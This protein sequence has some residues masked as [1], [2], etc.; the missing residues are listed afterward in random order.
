[1][2]NRGRGCCLVAG[3]GFVFLGVIVFQR[4]D[5]LRAAGAVDQHAGEQLGGAVDAG[6]DVAAGIFLSDFLT[7]LP[8]GSSSLQGY[9]KN[10]QF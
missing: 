6:P 1:M 8:G 7:L 9:E 3:A 2:T 4:L 5:Q 10:S